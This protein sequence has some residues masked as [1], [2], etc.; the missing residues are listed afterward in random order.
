MHR[1]FFKTMLTAACALAPLA[2]VPAGPAQA[3]SVVRPSQEIV[4]SIGRGQL[5]AVP[6][7][8]ADLFVATMKGTYA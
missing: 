5:I 7:N 6:G 1:S 8:M 3:Q 4:L 2:A